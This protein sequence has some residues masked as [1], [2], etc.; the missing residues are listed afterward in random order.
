MSVAD[1][2]IDP[3]IK[4]SAKEEFLQKGFLDASLQEICKN[5]GVT[6]GALYKRFKGK[7]ELFCAL[8]ESTVQDLE[9]V[10]RQK[11]AL[12]MT[13]TDEQLKKAWDMDRLPMPSGMACAKSSSILSTSSTNSFFKFPV[14]FSCTTPRGS[15]SILPCKLTRRLYSVLN[16]AMCERDSPPR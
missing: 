5:A 12:P 7:E 1:R 16:A 13:L 10:V 6:T 15:F 11:S 4:E 14:P 3:R 8:V 9:E 2:S